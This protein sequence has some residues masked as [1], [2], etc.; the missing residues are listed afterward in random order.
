MSKKNPEPVF[1]T[2]DFQFDAGQ[3]DELPRKFSGIAYSGEL[4]PGRN[5]VI[6]LASAKVLPNM[7]L[8]A[9]HAH[10][11]TIG[12]ISEVNVGGDLMVGGELFSD[13]DP[14]A[15][16][17]ATK[18]KRGLKYQ[19]SVG[20]YDAVAEFVPAGKSADVNGR[21]FP[22]PVGILRKGFV[23]E[24][25]IVPL[26]ADSKTR[27]HFFSESDSEEQTMTLEELSAQVAELTTENAKLKADLLAAD[28]KL[29]QVARAAREK[30]VKALFEATGREFSEDAAQAYYAMSAEIFDQIDKDL[31]SMMKELPQHLFREHQP[32]DMGTP[33]KSALELDAQSRG[34]VKN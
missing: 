30:Q 9:G 27:A 11:K 19:M 13:I 24:V 21:S 20:L 12:L 3:S 28:E 34:W 2:A 14:V 25:S 7:P 6:D 29:A 18:H 32:S 1:L 10:D 16:D 31:R 22:G 26:G 15:K 8:F 17:M 4:I 23:R 33:G 5:L